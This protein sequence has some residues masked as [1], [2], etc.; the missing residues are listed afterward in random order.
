MSKEM[1]RYIDDFKKI[2]LKENE[3]FNEKLNKSDVRSSKFTFLL[4]KY[5][6]EEIISNIESASDYTKYELNDMS[7]G[8]LSD[9]WY[10]L[11]M[12]SIVDL[13]SDVRSSK[14]TFLLDKY[15]PDHDNILQIMKDKYGYGDLSYGWMEEFEQTKDSLVTS[16][17]EYAEKFNKFIEEN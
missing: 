9:I 16:D 17:E 10:S 12:D 8:D 2:L 11:D 1:R 15:I 4:H 6:K 5:G 14:F 3:E 13:D 7:I